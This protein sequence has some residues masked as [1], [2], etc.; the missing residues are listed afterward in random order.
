[1]L[2]RQIA[3]NSDNCQFDKN[4][5]SVVGFNALN[6]CEKTVLRHLKSVKTTS[7]YW[8]YDEY[9]VKNEAQEAGRFLRDNLKLFGAEKIETESRFRDNKCIVEVQMAPSPVSQVKMIDRILNDWQEAGDFIPE[10]TAIV[11][12]D[13]NLLI[14]LMYSIPPF[15]GEYNVSM[16][17]PLKNSA[18]FGFVAH[19]VSLRRNERKNQDT[20]LYYYKDIL[21]IVNHTFVQKLFAEDAEIINNKINSEKL[22]YSH[23]PDFCN[24]DFINAILYSFPIESAE[25]LE[26]LQM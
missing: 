17:F 1:M 18:S 16:G 6:K 19:V 14:P 12:G 26:W 15:V 8:D 11:L 4:K 13:E 9:Y 24:N 22:I 7:F 21:A 10:K 2:Y 3:E 25:L 23:P 20:T 5:Y